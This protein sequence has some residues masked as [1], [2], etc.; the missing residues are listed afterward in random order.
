MTWSLPERVKR[1]VLPSYRYTE[2]DLT[3]LEMIVAET[4]AAGVVGVAAWEEAEAKDIP[5]GRSGLLLHGLYVSPESQRRGI[6]ARL[7][8]A[9]LVA[10]AERKL[11]GLLVKAQADAAPFFQARGMV[12]LPVAKPERDY[13]NRFWRERPDS[14]STPAVN[15]SQA[16]M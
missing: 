14:A 5:D 10:L 2:H 1:L 8:D 7:L 12:A 9:A 16:R 15:D 3:H 11:D 13:P 4:A 6:G